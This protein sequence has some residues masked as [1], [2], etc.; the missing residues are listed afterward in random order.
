M[1]TC[2][3]VLLRTFRWWR[4]SR[5]GQRRQEQ[6]M[7]ESCQAAK[8]SHGEQLRA[9]PKYQRGGRWARWVVGGGWW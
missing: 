9:L 3:Y 4:P 7:Q 8:E 6:Q 5:G 1:L 2:F